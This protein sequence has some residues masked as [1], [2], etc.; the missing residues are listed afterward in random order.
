MRQKKGHS[1]LTIAAHLTNHE[2]IAGKVHKILK[3]LTTHCSNTMTA[4]LEYLDLGIQKFFGGGSRAPFDPH[5]PLYP[6]LLEGMPSRPTGACYALF[7][8]TDTLVLTES[9]SI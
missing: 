8:A 6:P 7:I 2:F 3:W 9:E 4:L 1:Q 5:L